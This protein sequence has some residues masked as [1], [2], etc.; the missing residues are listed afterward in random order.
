MVPNFHF[1]AYQEGQ[2]L[3]HDR[4]PRPPLPAQFV[5][6]EAMS[7][8]GW[9]V[10]RGYDVAALQDLARYYGEPEEKV[11]KLIRKLDREHGLGLQVVPILISPGDAP[12]GDS[13]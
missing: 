1:L 11:R 6:L 4:Q 8:L 2:E 3:Y 10:A 9:M 13:R 12:E 7:W 5:S